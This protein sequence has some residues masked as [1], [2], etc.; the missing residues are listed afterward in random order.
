MTRTENRSPQR[1][2]R[3][4]TEEWS[5]PGPPVRGS[6]NL[7]LL[8]VRELAGT[9]FSTADLSAEERNRM[10]SFTR[11]EDRL[12]YAAAHVALRSLLASCL[13]APPAGLVF[14]R[15]P[16]PCCGAPH[17]R[18]SLEHQD[19][20]LHFSLSHGG[21]LVLI[22]VASVPV[23]VDV[24]AVP[25]TEAAL[26]LANV[27][28][29]TERAEVFSAAR[30]E[31]PRL[32]TQLWTRKE[33]YLKGLGTGLGRDPAADYLG[34]ADTP[35][36]PA[37]WTLVDIETRPGHAAAAAVRGPVEDCRL[38]RLRPDLVLPRSS[39]EV[40]SISC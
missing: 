26:E 9:T 33:A 12:R 7:W 1:L 30:T 23:G 17:G 32:F 15:E 4:A 11:A 40:F 28:H 8:D 20:P 10:A 6:L 36:R 35:P 13:G 14:T 29:A 25:D 18:P 21:D 24:E 37:N 27:L 38:M 3:A 22:G 31:Q 39:G 2:V 19:L 5:A 16:C 34:G